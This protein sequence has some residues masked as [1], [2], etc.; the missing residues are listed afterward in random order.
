MSSSVVLNLPD[1]LDETP[2][3]PK[4]K[5]ISEEDGP[6]FRGTSKGYPGNRT[7]QILGLTSISTDPVVA[8]IFATQSQTRHGVTGLVHVAMPNDLADLRFVEGHPAYRELELELRIELQPAEFSKRASITLTAQEARAILSDMEIEL[9]SK[10][11]SHNAITETLRN[12]SRLEFSQ[13]QTFLQKALELK[14]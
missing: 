11:Y 14:S 2:D 3:I 8:T 9:P 12:T 1:L 4:W 10:I 6:F 5:V 7:S 13:I